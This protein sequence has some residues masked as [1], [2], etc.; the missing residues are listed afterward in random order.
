MTGVKVS[1]LSPATAP[2]L[3]DSTYLVNGGNPRN[4]TLGALITFLESQGLV[5]SVNGHAGV[6]GAV[7]LVK[8]DVGLGNV[9]N[10]NPVVSLNSLAGA[11]TLAGGSGIT[12]TI[13]GNI[14]TISIGTLQIPWGSMT[15][16]LANQADLSAVLASVGIQ[17]G[18]RAVT[19][20]GNFLP[21][22]PSNLWV[23]VNSSTPVSMN[24]PV[25]VG[26]VIGSL[27][28]IRQAGAG[29]VAITSDLGVVIFTPNGSL[30]TTGGIGT[31]LQLVCI[32]T[33][34]WE[35]R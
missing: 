29:I 34:A 6:A 33:D 32:G 16:T 9:P 22:D 21:A 8:S 3:Q 7:T 18:I 12:L 30:T 23:S 31:R 26:Q 1:A 10:V 17:Q 25:G 28:E 4:L 14:V 11:V 19:A 13:Q 2:G 15:G 24:M 20:A 5:A 35:Y 27:I